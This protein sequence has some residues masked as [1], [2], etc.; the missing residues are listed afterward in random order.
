M[1]PGGSVI[2]RYSKATWSGSQ[3]GFADES[4]AKFAEARSK[5]YE[6]LFGKVQ[7]VFGEELPLIPHI[8]VHAYSRR[9]QD[10]GDVCTLV[11]S[12]MSDLAMDVRGVKA[13][14]RTELIFYCAEPK[15]EYVETMRWLA[16]FPHD[17]KDL[18]RLSSHH[19]E[20]ESSHALLGRSCF[21]HDSSASADRET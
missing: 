18:D 9:G 12:G 13:P 19:S 16:H 15:Q 10:G 17:Q 6:R 21:G 5:V 4:L 2:H 11:T 3:I 14:R 20:W 1:S 7:S 8:D